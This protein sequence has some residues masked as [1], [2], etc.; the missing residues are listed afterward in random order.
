MDSQ[1][2][3]ILNLVGAIFFVLW[4][5]SGRKGNSRRGPLNLRRDPPSPGRRDEFFR[6]S[7]PSANTPAPRFEQMPAR[8]AEPAPAAR[9]S[10]PRPQAE[11]DAGK[12]LNARF[13][14]NGHD[15]DAY[16][17]LGLPAGSSLSA[18]TRRYQE[19]VR[20]ADRGQLEFYECAYQAILKK[21]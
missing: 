18:V 9:A 8:R 12:M 4:F 1:L 7:P 21:T 5:L 14:Y 13:I 6:E 10:Q 11:R 15:W 2:F 19:M 16:E 17:V 20:D 3:F